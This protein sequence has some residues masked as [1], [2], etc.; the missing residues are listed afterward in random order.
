MKESETK[1]KTAVD[2]INCYES[3]EYTAKVVN[4]YRG[5]L[6]YE[7]ELFVRCKGFFYRGCVHVLRAFHQY[8]PDKTLMCR[9]YDSNYPNPNFRNGCDF[10]PYTKNEIKEIYDLDQSEG[11]CWNL[12]PPILPNLEDLLMRVRRT[13]IIESP[14]NPS[15]ENQSNEVGQTLN[16]NLTKGN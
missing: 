16:E 6:E 5:T 13:R 7:E 1:Y 3:T 2:K 15:L 9:I 12:P 4:V 8:I 11:R 14:L 10:V